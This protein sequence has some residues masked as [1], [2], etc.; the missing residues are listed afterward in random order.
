MV[1]RGLQ[2]LYVVLILVGVCVCDIPA[3]RGLAIGINEAAMDTLATHIALMTV[4]QLNQYKDY[5]EISGSNDK[6]DYRISNIVV[7]A[8][9]KDVLMEIEGTN[10]VKITLEGVQ[11]AMGS[12]YHVRAKRWPHPKELGSILV[13]TADPPTGI[14]VE[15]S[16]TVNTDG[17]AV[18]FDV[19]SAKLLIAHSGD[20]RVYVHCANV[21]CLIPVRDIA[22]AVAAA[23][24]PNAESALL[25]SAQSSFDNFTQF[26]PVKLPIPNTN[27]VAYVAG[28]AD[29]FLAGK[30]L[31]YSAVGTVSSNASLDP[32]PFA[33]GDI[34]LSAITD[35]GSPYTLI[36]TPYVAKSLLFSAFKFHSL[37]RV[38]RNADLPSGMPIQLNCSD[39]VMRQL[40]PGLSACNNQ[41][42]ALHVDLYNASD[43]T[44]APDQ[45]AIPSITFSLGFYNYSDPTHASLAFQLAFTVGYKGSISAFSNDTGSYAQLKGQ[46]NTPVRADTLQTNVGTLKPSVLTSLVL[47]S[48][49]KLSIQEDILLPQVSMVALHN[50]KADIT[51]DAIRVG[52]EVSAK[53]FYPTV[54]CEGAANGVCASGNLCCPFG[55]SP[56]GGG[57]CCE[58]YKSCPQNT[59]CCDGGCCF[60]DTLL[61]P[62]SFPLA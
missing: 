17:N 28:E 20:V 38:V 13:Y 9:V 51:K 1:Q 49:A 4:G 18:K 42:L 2:V 39:P 47:L 62:L 48:A 43:F 59:H 36:V 25:A 37:K 56:W 33:P 15:I 5:P 7:D 50:L 35:A 29:T 10:E 3:K 55:C 34:P 6:A 19:K 12:S 31:G 30:Y 61:E 40:A 41:L 22:E 26:L 16:F 11:F 27:L 23:F 45:W 14:K 44:L 8:T 21:I 58:N 57:V 24:V 32:P 60:G 52:A 46:L 53:P 54:P